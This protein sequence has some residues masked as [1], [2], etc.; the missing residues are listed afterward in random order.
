MRS[1]CYSLS[2]GNFK[3]YLP[4]PFMRSTISLL[5]LDGFQ[6]IFKLFSTG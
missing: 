6:P 3:L 1:I 2:S 5:L 4:L